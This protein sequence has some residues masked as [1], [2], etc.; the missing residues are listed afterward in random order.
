VT[1]AGVLRLAVL[2]TVVAGC[3]H[4]ARTPV[5]QSPVQLSDELS[6]RWLAP[7][8]EQAARAGASPA[9][10]LASGA[11]APGDSIGGRLSLAPTDCALLLARGSRSIEDL[12]L[13]VYGDDGTLLGGDE[14]A[15]ENASAVVCPPHPERVYAFA[16]VAAGRG[17]LALSAQLVKPE[18]AERVA[19][20]VG[21]A[22]KPHEQ[23]LA[24]GWPGLEDA[25]AEHRRA[26]G[27]TW[28]DARRVA[29]PLDP[30]VPTRTSAVVDAG[31]CVD[32]LVLPSEDVAFVELTALD[33]SGR[34]VGRA[35]TEER[36]PSLRA[37]SATHAELTLE[38]RPHAG[39][40]LAALILSTTSDP[41]ALSATPSA[42]VLDPPEDDPRAA[43][44]FAR[45]LTR[46]GYGVPASTLRGVTGVGKRVSTPLDLPDGCSRIDVA[47]F[48][49]ARGVDAW[50][51]DANGALIAHDD[52]STRATLFACGREPHARLDVE[53]IARPGP[54]AVELR[55]AGGAPGVLGQHALAAGRL[56]GRLSEAGRVATPRDLPPPRVV[57]LAQGRLVMDEAKVPAGQCLDLALGLGAG[58]EGAE[59]RVVNAETSDDLSLTRGTYSTITEACALERNRPLDVR[60]ELRVAAGSADALYA[61]HPRTPPA[62][63]APVPTK[64]PV[65]APV[66]VPS[67]SPSVTRPAPSPAPRAPAR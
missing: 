20:A 43:A 4:G 63:A 2:S 9:T 42:V 12:D 5:L 39:R 50:L 10:V 26:L 13:F 15:S 18:A 47:V 34:I 38:L 30:R 65:Q 52:G 1:R 67:P 60:V 46:A 37:C 8:V 21:A 36:L 56:L 45:T 55:P 54:Y 16:R 58:A 40:G 61:K 64:A 17:L 31:Q 19:R 22:G 51:W 23:A 7:D 44:A 3:A 24:G 62:S 53:P 25:L 14:T 33:D 11:G 66:P 27:G 28:K 32:V 59:I 35:P 41:N 49:P 48:A 6:T 57:S 29:V